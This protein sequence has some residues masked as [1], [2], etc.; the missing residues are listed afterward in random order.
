MRVITI[1]CDII[2]KE[3]NQLRTHTSFDDCTSDVVVAQVVSSEQGCGKHGGGTMKG[4]ESGVDTMLP[5][6]YVVEW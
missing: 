3:R 2:K 4:G 6:A 1:T 5:R